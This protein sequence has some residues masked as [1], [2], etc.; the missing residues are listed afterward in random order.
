MMKWYKKIGFGLVAILMLT[1]CSIDSMKQ[2]DSREDIYSGEWASKQEDDTCQNGVFLHLEFLD[3]STAK[4]SDV[5]FNYGATEDMN[6]QNM[7]LDELVDP[8]QSKNDLIL[9]FNKD[10]VAETEVMSQMNQVTF[11]AKIEL[12]QEE[13]VITLT[14]ESGEVNDA[15]IFHKVE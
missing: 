11:S 3:S 6:C 5:K 14:Q 9:E 1:S 10:G 15:I 8:D 13:I 2:S 12:K 4:M 7:K